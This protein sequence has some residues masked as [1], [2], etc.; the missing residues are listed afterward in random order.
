MVFTTP[1]LKKKFYISVLASTVTPSPFLRVSRQI[2]VLESHNVQTPSFLS[3][4]FSYGLF[5]FPGLTST[6]TRI[7]F[8]IDNSILLHP[9]ETWG[10]RPR[11]DA[12]RVALDTLETD[13]LRRLCFKLSKRSLAYSIRS[14]SYTLGGF[15]PVFG[16]STSV[17]IPEVFCLFY[18]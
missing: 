16:V 2:S 9:P 15:M 18:L 10:L 6:R 1:V 11:L 5:A 13:I 7:I 3:I 12:S 4:Q 14:S 17:I 8:R